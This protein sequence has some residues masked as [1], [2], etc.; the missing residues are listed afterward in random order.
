MSS[1]DRIALVDSLNRISG[2]LIGVASALLGLW[3][4]TVLLLGVPAPLLPFATAV[5]R[6]E[7]FHLVRALSPT[8]GHALRAALEHVTDS[9]ATHEVGDLLLAPRSQSAVPIPSRRPA[10]V[11]ACPG[12][13]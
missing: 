13:R 3:L 12:Y 1:L 4:L 2:A 5:R 7:T 11:A 6:S 8:W 10:M 9:D